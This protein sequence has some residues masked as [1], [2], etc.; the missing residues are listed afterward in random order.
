[1]W[2]SL[3]RTS[4]VA[5]RFHRISIWVGQAAVVL[6]VADKLKNITI[7]SRARRV[8]AEERVVILFAEPD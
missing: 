6:A 3:I 1:M 7:L 4:E 2:T 8:I 5:F